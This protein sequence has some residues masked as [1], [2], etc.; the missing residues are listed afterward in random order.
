MVPSNTEVED[1]APPPNSE[2]GLT[3]DVDAELAGVL[4]LKVEDAPP[5]TDGLIVSADAPPNREP[6]ATVD[7]GVPPKTEAVV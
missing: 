2:D 3:S 5:K 4:K 7:E 1:G 6:A